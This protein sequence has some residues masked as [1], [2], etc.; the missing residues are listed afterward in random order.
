MKILVTGSSRG[1][2]EEICTKLS[3]LGHE[4]IAPSRSE[5]NLASY[6]S[7]IEFIKNLD[8]DFDGLVNNAGLNHI[9]SYT[10]ISLEQ[11]NETMMVNCTAPFLLSQTLIRHSFL[12]KRFGR[13]VNIGTIWL[14]HPREG[15]TTYTLSKAAL[16][17]LTKSLA[18][19]FG[20]EGIL[21]NMIS[22]GI[23][24]TDLTR[25]NNSAQEIE[26][27]SKLNSI[28]RLISK[29]DIASM[30][31]FLLTENKVINGQNIFI[32]GGFKGGI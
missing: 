18:I 28:E 10:N 4:V 25:L 7:I 30:V 27:L 29:S 1:I 14:K 22:P 5:L 23:V 3:K 24:D 21:S 12:P 15:R 6:P 8:T 31:N 2:G 17:S 16:E 20:R 32:D 19:E 13:I 26:M 11:Y 9:E